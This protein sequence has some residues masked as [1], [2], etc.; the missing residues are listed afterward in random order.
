MPMYCTATIEL[1]QFISP[2]QVGDMLVQLG[3]SGSYE[4]DV[5]FIGCDLE[6]DE[7]RDNV[8]ALALTLRDCLL[9]GH[10]PFEI[11]VKGN[12]D[13]DSFDVL[14]VDK[15]VYLKQAALIQ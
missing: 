14:L 7:A 12:D 2:L 11:V 4:N 15:N 5:V 13:L 6:E 8:L 9:D 1:N 3:F 10:E